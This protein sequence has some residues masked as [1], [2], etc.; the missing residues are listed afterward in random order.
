[1]IDAHQEY[2]NAIQFII[3]LIWILEEETYPGIVLHSIPTMLVLGLWLIIHLQINLAS[4]P[5]L[6][7]PKVGLSEL[8]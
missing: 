6:G 4:P 8:T 2:Y 3:V 7:Q 1:M 5:L